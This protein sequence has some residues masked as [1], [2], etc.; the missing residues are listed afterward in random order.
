MAILKKPG[1]LVRGVTYD[2]ASKEDAVGAT[3][4]VRH[5]V[6]E[7]GHVEGEPIIYGLDSSADNDEF[8]RHRNR[9]RRYM[10]VV[11][12][13]VILTISHFVVG[14]PSIYH[15]LYLWHLFTGLFRG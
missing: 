12:V 6:D 11:Y 2:S 10:I 5:G 3:H 8:L 14:F 9:G 1:N 4:F 7:R 13:I 15:F